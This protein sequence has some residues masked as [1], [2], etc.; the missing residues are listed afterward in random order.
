MLCVLDELLQLYVIVILDAVVIRN[1]AATTL[2][3]IKIKLL[4]SLTP[5]LL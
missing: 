5:F 2:V 3:L 4:M 1:V